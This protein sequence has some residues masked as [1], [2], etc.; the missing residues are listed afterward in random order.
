MKPNEELAKKYYSLFS[1]EKANLNLVK[2]EVPVSESIKLLQPK[3]R[4]FKP[5]MTEKEFDNIFSDILKE[6]NAK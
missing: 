1:E 3:T 2:A 4:E 6:T 5:I